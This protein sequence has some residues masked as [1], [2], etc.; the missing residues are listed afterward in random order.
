[1]ILRK[2]SLLSL[3][4]CV[5]FLTPPQVETTSRKGMLGSHHVCDSLADASRPKRRYGIPS[6]W[7]CLHIRKSMSCPWPM[8]CIFWDVCLK[9][10]VQLFSWNVLSCQVVQSV[11]VSSVCIRDLFLLWASVQFDS[12]ARIHCLSAFVDLHCMILLTAHLP[13]IRYC[14]NSACYDRV[15]KPS[16]HCSMTW[17]I[18]LPA[19]SYCAQMHSY[20]A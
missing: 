2:L 19:L 4:P 6:K 16:L 3:N 14:S 15:L 17:N 1:M 7:H 8:H 11:L 10:Q 18:F 12:K 5:I 13:C 20:V 9:C